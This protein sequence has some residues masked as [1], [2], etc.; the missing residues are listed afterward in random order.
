MQFFTGI[1]P[2]LIPGLPSTTKIPG[3]T[4]KEFVDFLTSFYFTLTHL[5][6]SKAFLNFRQFMVSLLIDIRSVQPL[7][8]DCTVIAIKC[9]FFKLCTN[10][11][12]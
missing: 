4:Q 2:N 3:A 5:E 8:T 6:T 11:A 9:T 7:R 12:T 1:S 10:S